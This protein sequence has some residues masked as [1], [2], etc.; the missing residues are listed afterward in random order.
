MVVIRFT[1]TQSRWMRG[2]VLHPAQEEQ[3]EEDGSLT[4]SFTASHEVEVLQELLQHGAQAELIAPDW[5]RV[6]LVDELTRTISQY[7]CE[8]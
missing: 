5:L 3:L 4:V 7:H 1:P 6:K 8:K 2:V